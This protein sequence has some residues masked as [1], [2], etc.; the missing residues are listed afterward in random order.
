M[1]LFIAVNFSDAT[2]KTLLALRDELRSYA[3]RGN[4]SSPENL[5]LTL[6]FLGEC[7]LNQ[8]TAAELSMDAVKFE[9]FDLLIERVGRFSGART[10]ADKTVRSDGGRGESESLWWAGIRGD[11]P[12]L[13]LHRQLTENLAGAGFSLDS[14]RFNPHITLGR[15]VVTDVAPWRVEPFGETVRSID[16]MKS[17]RI[18]GR[19]TYTP[20][21]Q[22]A[23]E[24]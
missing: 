5:H 18:N 7:G 13:E 11:K 15:R 6:A 23:Y 24:V 22:R 10:V 12:L 19:L 1:R 8:I 9:P 3:E 2:R 14:R 20:V 16:L 21:Y 17:E 4:F